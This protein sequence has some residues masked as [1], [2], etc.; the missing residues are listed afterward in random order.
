MG[1]EMCIRD[2]ALRSSMARASPMPV[3]HH[4]APVSRLCP[5][6]AAATHVFL[7]VDAVKRPLTPPYEG[8][9]PVLRRSDSGKTFDILRNEKT[10]TV[11]ID[12]LKPAT[13]LESGSCAS[14][15]SPTESAAAPRSGPCSASPSAVPTTSSGRA[16]RPV[17][18]YQA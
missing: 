10:F 2:R 7:R 9:F 5:L 12:R 14:P 11:S 15:V 18:R 16:S 8:P 17:C 3:V 6:L 1:S 4:G 13:F